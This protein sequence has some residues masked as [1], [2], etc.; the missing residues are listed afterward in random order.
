MLMVKIIKLF[1]INPVN[2]K[3]NFVFINIMCNVLTL[4]ILQ[5]ALSFPLV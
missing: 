5:L 2:H 3:K 4:W 1:R